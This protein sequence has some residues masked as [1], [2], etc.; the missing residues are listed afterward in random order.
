MIDTGVN[1][2]QNINDILSSMG[3][4][5][6]YSN[7][8]FKA[9]ASATS[10]ATFS[11]N[12]DDVIGDLTTQSRLSRKDNFNSIKGKFL[13]ETTEWEQTDYPALSPSSFVT[14]D[15]GE[16]IFRDLDLSFTTSQSMAQRLAKIQ[17]Y[18]ARQPLTV[19]GTFKCSAFPLDTNDLV[20][21]SNTRY[22]WSDKV[23]RVSQWGFTNDKNGLTISMTLTE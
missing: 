20:K 10:T 1:P 11:L 18:Q 5:I 14:D 16:T 21:F 8:T 23:F 6:T 12:E 4:V 3:G 17:L 22:G 19:S 7:G 2:R 9:F 15:N 13:S